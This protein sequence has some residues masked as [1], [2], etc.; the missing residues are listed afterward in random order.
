[1]RRFWIALVL[2]GTVGWV[3][4]QGPATS[5]LRDAFNGPQLSW[6]KGRANVKFT[7]DAHT[8]TAQFAALGT[9]VR[10]LAN[11]VRAE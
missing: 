6:V 11:H 8:I 2:L 9:D 5:V 10:I 1:M 3:A 4:A 7:E